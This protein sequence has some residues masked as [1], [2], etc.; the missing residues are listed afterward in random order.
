MLLVRRGFLLTVGALV[1]Q[2]GLLGRMEG[3]QGC[4][5]PHFCLCH[6]GQSVWGWEGLEKERALKSCS[7]MAC[8]GGGLSLEGPTVVFMLL[9]S[10][11]EPLLVDWFGG[12]IGNR[13]FAPMACSACAQKCGR[14]GREGS[15]DALFFYPYGGGT[16][17]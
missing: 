6:L 1:L 8:G 3:R 13:W 14:T 16:H 5:C 15:G 2:V 4:Q 9:W 17:W 10:S 11:N 7:L 12:G